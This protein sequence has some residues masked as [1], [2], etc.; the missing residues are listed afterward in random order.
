MEEEEEADTVL[1]CRDVVNFNF[2]EEAGASNKGPTAVDLSG[3]DEFGIK[4]KR[5][6]QRDERKRTKKP[7]TAREND[8]DVE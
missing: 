1:N 4:R 5:K 3:D 6:N 2:V 8:D 7:K